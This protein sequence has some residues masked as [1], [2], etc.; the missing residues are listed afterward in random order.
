MR[1]VLEPTRL[2]DA[3]T[4]QSNAHSPFAAPDVC[5]PSEILRCPALLKR[6]CF[7][8]LCR[9]AT[10]RHCLCLC[11][12]RPPHA[13]H[14][15]DNRSQPALSGSGLALSV[16]CPALSGSCLGL[17]GSCLALSAVAVQD[18]A[19]ERRLNRRHPHHL[20]YLP[21]LDPARTPTSIVNGSWECVVAEK[22]R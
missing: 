13:H 16:S 9:R 7:A 8:L 1:S 3:N 6:G 21:G 4:R 17:C 20:R 22:K 15:A 12:C 10:P 18:R 5:I 14:P 19:V 11:P 2:L